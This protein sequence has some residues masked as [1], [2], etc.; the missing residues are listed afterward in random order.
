MIDQETKPKP[1]SVEEPRDEGLDETNCSAS[2]DTPETDAHWAAI[3]GSAYA[4]GHPGR[5]LMEKLERQRNAAWKTLREIRELV[6]ADE[7]FGATVEAL[8]AD[9]LREAE[10]EIERLQSLLNA[11]GHAAAACGS[12]FKQTAS[13]PS[14][15]PTC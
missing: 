10:A 12:E 9:P 11:K 14:H 7:S 5:K 2:S 3:D 13:S 4:T 6:V 15:E 8:F 1:A